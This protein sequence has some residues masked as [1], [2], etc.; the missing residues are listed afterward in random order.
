MDQTLHN[1]AAKFYS[2][3]TITINIS[4]RSLVR[5]L[6]SQLRSVISINLNH[7]PSDRGSQ[8]LN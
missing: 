7:D 5:R 1:A 6:L 2:D 8:T 3:T 4:N